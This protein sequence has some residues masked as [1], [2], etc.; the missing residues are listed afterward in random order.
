MIL[1]DLLILKTS[2]KNRF[3]YMQTSNLDGET[4]IKPREAIMHTQ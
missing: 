3:C 2:L 4:T 1:A